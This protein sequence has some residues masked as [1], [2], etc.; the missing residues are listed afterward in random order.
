MA[1][2]SP[3][4]RSLDAHGCDVCKHR[5]PKHEETTHEGKRKLLHRSVIDAAFLCLSEKHFLFNCEEFTKKLKTWEPLGIDQKSLSRFQFE[6]ERL[7]ID[8]R[9]EKYCL[10]KL[11][12]HILT[13][14]PT[15]LC[16][17][18]LKAI[19]GSTFFSRRQGSFDVSWKYCYRFV[20]GSFSIARLYQKYLVTFIQEAFSSRNW[21]SWH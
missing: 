1:K 9:Q 19:K 3:C 14:R 15:S 11:K 8:W 21:I 17:G 13:T 20:H 16:Q 7:Q 6:V 2:A 18:F 12:Q 10:V 5:Q 4:P